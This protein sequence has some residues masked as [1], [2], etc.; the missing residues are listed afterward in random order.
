MPSD[1]AGVTVASLAERAM[2]LLE[3]RVEDFRSTVSE[4][5]QE[6][7]DDL[8]RRASGDGSASATIAAEL[9]PFA[10]GL[11][12]PD[13]FIALLGAEDESLTPESIDVLAKADA[14]LTGFAHGSNHLLRVEPGGDLRDVVKHGLAHVGQVFGASR[15]VELAR[16]ARFD[17]VEHGY[18]LGPLPFRLWNRAER[19]LA[20]PLVIEV[21]GEDCLPA[22][23]GEFLDGSVTL[24]IVAVGPT[25]PAPL[26]RLIT[27]GTFVMQ[28]AD[29]AALE[30]LDDVHHPAIVLLFD[31]ER[32]EQA[33]FVH[34]PDAGEASW[35][36]I[37]VEQM[38]SDA[39]VGRGR[40]P[41]MWL[42]EVV[43]LRG[44]AEAPEAPA[45]SSV[46]AP[47]P[48]AASAAEIA[49]VASESAGE[50][51]PV[52]RLA[53]WLLSRTDLSGL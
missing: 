41:P 43:H 53:A 22:G 52:D 6:V 9:G 40:R 19:D 17:P 50:A 12:D 2:A 20:P 8:R 10:A 25:T 32:L 18:L 51:D 23:L 31:E 48:R 37:S 38:P 28:T 4:A 44:L 21:R 34:D 49:P 13:R 30:R 45:A 16:A 29:P 3:R 15:A 27:P 42:E 46:G 26:S 14:I 24:V 7:H 36:R 39:V 35:A 33:R 5:E 47:A 11:I 1:E